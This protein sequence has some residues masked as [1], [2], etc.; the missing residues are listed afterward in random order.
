MYICG[1]PGLG[2]TACLMEI[3]KELVTKYEFSFHYINGLN[4][5]KAGSFYTTMFEE[6]TGKPKIAKDACKYLG[7]L[8][9]LKTRFHVPIWK[10]T[11]LHQANTR[12]GEEG[13]DDKGDCHR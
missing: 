7:K 5:A 2:K 4:M 1:V 11:S 10:A 12:L 3:I 8:F 13:E 6:I 9:C